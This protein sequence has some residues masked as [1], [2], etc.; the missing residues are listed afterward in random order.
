MN[1]LTI[2]PATGEYGTNADWECGGSYL[3]V[4]NS[5]IPQFNIDNEYVGMRVDGWFRSKE[6]Y[7]E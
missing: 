6:I 2:N 7:A 5:Y 3:Y 1:N 4:N